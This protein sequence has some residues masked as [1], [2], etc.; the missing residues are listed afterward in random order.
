MRLLGE[1]RLSVSRTV[2]SRSGAYGDACSNA[3]A[4]WRYYLKW[5][6]KEQ[7]SQHRFVE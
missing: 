4:R 5:T 6:S 2:G 1:L 3:Y 7:T